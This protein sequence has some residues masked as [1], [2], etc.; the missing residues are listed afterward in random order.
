M[1]SGTHTPAFPQRPG[2]A[3]SRDARAIRERHREREADIAEAVFVVAY[4]PRRAV[5]RNQGSEVQYVVDNPSGMSFSPGSPVRIGTYTGHEHGRFIIAGTPPT[6]GR[7]APPPSRTIRV[8]GISAVTLLGRPHVGLGADGG[9]LL[10][11]KYLGGIYDSELGAVDVTSISG[12]LQNVAL[13]SVSP[14][15]FALRYSSPARMYVANFTAETLAGPVTQDAGGGQSA[16]RTVYGAG[17]SGAAYWV[18]RSTSGGTFFKLWRLDADLT[19]TAIT[20]DGSEAAPG[21]GSSS[22]FTFVMG[23]DTALS[24]CYGSPAGR[25]AMGDMQSTFVASDDWLAFDVDNSEWTNW[26][27]C[28][29]FGNGDALI[30]APAASGSVSASGLGRVTPGGTFTQLYTQTALGGP[31]VWADP[32]PDGSTIAVYRSTGTD[33]VARV[34]AAGGT[35]PTWEPIDDMPEGGKPGQLWCLD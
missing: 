34:L 32:S 2:Y 25:I 12:T 5:V 35:T 21:F 31:P 8:A 4:D 20:P 1:P 23:N 11:H 16:S 10:A 27:G 28:G 30:Y 9:S 15:I 17:G 13:M 14:L 3:S 29:V 7:S 26:D 18:R 22:A 6:Q 19:H 24:P 33:A